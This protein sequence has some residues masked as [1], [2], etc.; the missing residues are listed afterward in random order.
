MAVTT[1]FQM[2]ALKHLSDP[3]I[4]GFDSDK[5]NASDLAYGWGM[6]DSPLSISSHANA[7][8]L[9]A[10]GGVDRASTQP[11]VPLAATLAAAPAAVVS[12]RYLLHDMPVREKAWCPYSRRCAHALFNR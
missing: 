12:A 11:I 2:G 5:V 1:L 8:T 3:P 9:A 4:E 6:P 7:I 10:F